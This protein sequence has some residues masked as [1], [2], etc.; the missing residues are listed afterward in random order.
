MFPY[1]LQSLMVRYEWIQRIVF[2]Y[3][4]PYPIDGANSARACFKAGHC[5]CSNADRFRRSR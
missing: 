2:R 1:W 3:R 5:G 4:C